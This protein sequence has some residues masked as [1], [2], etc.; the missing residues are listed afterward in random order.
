MKHYLSMAVVA[1][2]LAA[3]SDDYDDTA[4]WNTVNEH[5]NRIAALEQW[6][7]EVNNNIAALQQLLNTN[8]MITSV[9][10]VMENGKEVGYTIAFLH[11]DPV[12]IYH[13]EK[14]EKGDKGEQ[15]IQGE[16]GVQG[17]P[18]KDG[19]NGDT[20]VVG[21][22]KGDDGNWYWT[23]DGKLMTDPQGNPIRANGEDGKDGQDG[24]P[25]QDG[26]PGADG[27]DGEPGDPA[28]TP[29]IG[30]GSSIEGGTIV[31]DNGVVQLDAWY[32]SVDGGATWYRI[33][34]DKGATGDKG[35]TGAQ[36]PQGDQGEQGE[37]GEQ[38]PQG[39]QGEQGPQ[40]IQGEQGD[41]WFACAPTLSEDGTYYIFTL[42]DGDDD[43]DNN[44]TIEVAAYQSLRILTEEEHNGSG[45]FDNGMV[46]V[47]GE[48]TFYL[49]MNAETDYKAIVAEVTPL[50]DDAVLT[51]AAS[52][53]SATVQEAAD[54]NITVTV[55]APSNGK[56]LLDVSLIRADGS[57]VTASRVLEAPG[58]EVVDGTYIV[59]TAK[60]LQAWAEAVKSTPS[61]SCTLAA[62]IDMTG[63]WTPIG[64]DY[65]NSYTGTF[66]GGN[67]T[68]TGLTVK[69]S[70]ENAGLFGYIGSNGMV[71]NVV[72]KHVQIASDYQNAYVGG[73]AGN[74]DGAI[75]NCSVSGSVSSRHTAGGVVG[76][77]FGGSITLCGSSATVKGTGEVGGVAGKTDNS[78]TLTACYAT[79]NVTFERASTINTFAGGVVGFNG[80]GSILTACY[81]TGNVTGTGTGTGS[82]YVGGVTG[83]N[84][85]GT[86]TAC[87]HATGTVSGPDGATGGVTGRNF[88]ASVGIPVI[89]AC[90][91]QNDQAQGIGDNQAGTGETTLVVDGN[92]T[93]AMNA[94]NNALS[95][96][97]WKY[98]SG[99]GNE[100]LTLQKQ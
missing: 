50:D 22:L 91:W 95:G 9:T 44:P 48:T 5:G 42:A 62:D 85:S 56:A 11:S 37:Q 23:L 16:Q 87:Y 34:G 1:M 59:Y 81:A 20:P 7:D 14:G 17:T 74:N 54:G 64:T 98:V 80:T 93:E 26:K 77:Q 73:V 35:D 61:T 15:G 88:N 94:M 76:Q 72:L 55:T 18:G 41:S 52:E 82:C 75:E 89:T 99:S 97:S 45:T 32:L 4:L 79:G 71:K 58:Y 43:P 24:Q 69:G 90:Y 33:S 100:P 10:P 6:Q 27:E 3:C 65:R 66:D 12:T 39:E 57:K 68:I 60:G 31:T 53:W 38:G 28:P 21:L 2:A 84:A 92:W 8:D 47:Q 30:L 83:D 46:E 36:G 25:G 70:D 13:G 51:R 63:E 78:A 19:A 96:T 49:S 40:G 67:H 29:Q 86:L